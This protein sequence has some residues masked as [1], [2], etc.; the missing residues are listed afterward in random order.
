[1]SREGES[2]NDRPSPAAG[3]DF[4]DFVGALVSERYALPSPPPRVRK[5]PQRAGPRQALHYRPSKPAEQ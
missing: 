1:M 3:E 5:G 2:D 4:M